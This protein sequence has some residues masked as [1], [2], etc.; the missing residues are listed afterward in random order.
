MN[1]HK[2]NNLFS[3]LLSEDNGIDHGT[4]ALHDSLVHCVLNVTGQMILRVHLT[5]T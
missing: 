3:A 2:Y 4:K 1:L 5:D